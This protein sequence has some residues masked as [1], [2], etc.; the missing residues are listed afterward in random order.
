MKVTWGNIPTPSFPMSGCSAVGSARRSGR[1]GRGFESRHS[2]HFKLKM[3][4]TDRIY[5]EM[6]VAEP[7]L[8]ELIGA[9][10]LQRLK[11]IDQAGFLE[12]HF[13]GTAH[14]RYEHSVGVMLLLKRYQA[15]IAEQIAG[16]LHDVSHSAFSHCAD[17]V[18]DNG[19]QATQSHQDDL[20]EQYVK[21]SELPA[22]LEKHGFNVDYILDDSNFPL[23][24]TELPD[25]CA[26][27]IDYSLRTAVV[28]G[29][30]EDAESVLAS[31]IANNG[32]WYFNDLE[33]ARNYT[34]LFR[35]LNDNYY[36]GLPSAVMFRTVGDYVKY[37]LNKGY[38]TVKDFYTTDR[39][40]LEKIAGHHH[41]DERL[42]LLFER[43][44][45]RI[46]FRNDPENF[47]AEVLCKNRLVDPLFL[48]EGKIQRFSESDS[49]Y[50]ELLKSGMA[51]KRYF[52]KFEK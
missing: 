47:E 38:I 7:V 52:I 6:E 19:T 10:S 27:R 31:L 23:K 4:I 2:D 34:R 46:P 12:P 21:K 3:R 9:P 39:Q 44:N 42:Q 15:E 5:G 18:M 17:Y 43:M 33:S 32:Q 8:V 26:D 40:V 22:I 13:P 51:P 1:R 11:G 28:F 14:T 20:H 16:L 49:S 29:D 36:A 37:A 50:Q 35:Y 45:N 25:L 48:S 24:E 41:H 30:L